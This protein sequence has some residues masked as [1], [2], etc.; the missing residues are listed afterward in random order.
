[1]KQVQNILC[2]GNQNGVHGRVAAKLAEIAMEYRVR[3]LVSRDGETVDC[4][5]ILDLLAMGL[6]HGAEVLLRAEGDSAK[7]ALVAATAILSQEEDP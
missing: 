4:S 3:L 7:E 6:V 2:I 5:S 1:M